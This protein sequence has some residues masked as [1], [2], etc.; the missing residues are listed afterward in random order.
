[1]Q[2]LPWNDCCIRLWMFYRTHRSSDTGNTRV[3][4]T[5]S[6]EEFDLKW[7]ISSNLHGKFSLGQRPRWDA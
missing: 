2:P 7:R 4:Y 1:M 5:L 3:K 6:G